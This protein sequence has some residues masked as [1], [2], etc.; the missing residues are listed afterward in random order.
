MCFKKKGSSNMLNIKREILMGLLNEHDG[1]TSKELATQLQVT[2][3]TIR[4]NIKQINETFKEDV[5]A[6]QKPHFKL[7]NAQKVT[8]Y[9]AQRQREDHYPNYTGDRPFLVY[10]AL[11]QNNW[12]KIDTLMEQLHI[13]RNEVEKT[14]KNL[15]QNMPE[16]LAIVATK[17]GVY[18]TG[19]LIWQNYFLGTLAVK[20][21]SRLVSNQY[22][23]LIFQDDFDKQAFRQYLDTLAL[24]AKRELQVSLSDKTLYILAIMHFLAVDNEQLLLATNLFQKEFMLFSNSVILQLPE[25]QIAL[26]QQ[27]LELHPYHRRY[28]YQGLGNL[29]HHLKLAQSDP[30]YFKLKIL[31]SKIDGMTIKYTK[32]DQKFIK[33]LQELQDT[34][35]QKRIVIYDPDSIVLSHYQDQLAPIAHLFS[36]LDIKATN[37]LFELDQL[38]HL[39][40]EEI[41]FTAKQ[42]RI[43]LPDQKY[44]IHFVRLDEHAKLA[45]I[46]LL[47]NGTH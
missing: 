23:R 26:Q 24:K 39:P 19:D 47:L 42:E 9:I 38:L 4:N 21:I 45:I 41:I 18:L 25:S 16:Q 34:V 30:N 8:D 14:I 2:Q 12:V 28:L 29:A 3:R 33:H 43:S 10:L 40:D 15:K 11:Y 36:E 35:L 27:L 5:I 7:Q 17:H 32:Q 44:N 1:L 20:R 31:K 46:R 22:L 6:Y 37:N 13:G